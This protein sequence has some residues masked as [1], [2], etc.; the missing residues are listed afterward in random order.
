MRGVWIDTGETPTVFRYIDWLLTV[1]LLMI[2]FY[3][4]LRAVTN[5]AAS[6]FYKLFISSLLMLIFGYAGEAGLMPALPAFVIGLAFWLFML[7]KL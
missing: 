7:Y 1:P 2:E 3:L 5:V 6:L 4:I